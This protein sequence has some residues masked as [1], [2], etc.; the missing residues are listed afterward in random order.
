M[1]EMHFYL[2]FGFCGFKVAKKWTMNLFK[3]SEDFGFP[4]FDWLDWK[5]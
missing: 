2:T 1:R 4:N 5:L 3:S